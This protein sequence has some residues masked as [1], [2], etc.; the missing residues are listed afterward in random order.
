[1]PQKYLYVDGVATR[2]VHAGPTTLPGHPPQYGRGETVVCLHGAGGNADLFRATAARLAER[3]TPVAFDQPAHGRSG[4]LDAL[5]S[6]KSRVAFTIGLL[7]AAAIERAVLLGHSLG[8]ALALQVALDHP[9]RVAG[10]VLVG[11]GARFDISQAK[12]DE[13]RLV[14]EGKARRPFDRSLYAADTKPEVLRAGFMEDLKTDPR[15]T[16]GDALALADW[17]VESRL[18]EL[19]RPTLVAHGAE[20]QPGT[21]E[22][23]QVVAER[24][25]GA[26]RSEIPSAGHMLPLEQPDA[27]ADAILPF[28]DRVSA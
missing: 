26:E 8:G 25:A 28:L 3:H 19:A 21:V 4:E 5:P 1:M 24:V 22:R 12:L 16:Y 2:V 17:N 18:G 23:A 6:V 20:E 7:D 13:L 15:A 9:E 14:T 27:L 10:L 11:S